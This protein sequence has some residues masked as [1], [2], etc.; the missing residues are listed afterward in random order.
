MKDQEWVKLT[1]NDANIKSQLA[2][3]TCEAGKDTLKY[4]GNTSCV[5]LEF[6]RQQFFIFDCG[7]GIKNLGDWFL[8]EKRQNIH[9]KIFISHPHW[10]HI[11]AIPFFTP[12]YIQGGEFEVLGANQGDVGMR[13]IVAAQ[14]GGVY[15]PIT[16]TPALKKR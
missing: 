7:S 2:T 8:A 5:T 9:A 10:D 15:F 13:K 1:L 11:N 16:R 12:L 4:G 14:M 3:V 6:P